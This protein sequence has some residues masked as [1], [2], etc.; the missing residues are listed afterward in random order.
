M[1]HMGRYLVFAYYLKMDPENCCGSRGT[2][3]KRLSMADSTIVLVCIGDRRRAPR[4]VTFYNILVVYRKPSTRS[5][6]CNNY[7]QRFLIM[8][9]LKSISRLIGDGPRGG[10]ARY[11]SHKMYN[12]KRPVLRY[13]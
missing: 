2:A 7:S 4:P 3:P 10:C 9:R 8:V 1:R 6:P 5:S 11:A 13:G 12:P